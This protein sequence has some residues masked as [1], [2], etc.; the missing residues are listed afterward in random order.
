MPDNIEPGNYNPVVSTSILVYVGTYATTRENS[1]F[2]Y[3]L[4]PL[5]GALTLLKGFKGGEN[6][7]YFVFDVQHQFL[8][9]VNECE[10]Y[11]GRAGGAVCAFAMDRKTGFL[12]LLNRTSSLGSLPVYITLSRNGKTALVANYKGGNISVFPI[13]ANGQLATASKLIQL[14]NHGT[15]PNKERQESPHA[16]CI[17]LS[18]DGRFV[19]VVDLGND[20]VIAYQ[21]DP[22]GSDISPDTA[23]TA[24]KTHP[25]AG[26]RQLRFHSNGRFA[27]LI[28][29]LKSIIIALAYNQHTG[30]FTEIQA[31]STLPAGYHKENKCGGIRLTSVGRFLYASNRGHNSLAVY[32][33]DEISGRLTYLENIPSGGAWPREFTVVKGSNILL[34]ANQH[35]G[36]VDS[37]KI[38]PTSGCLTHSEYQ[39]KVSKPVFIETLACHTS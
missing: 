26:P 28:H 14:Q 1:I 2:L 18:P 24:F 30:T 34:V 23:I 3:K 38:N 15:G 5:T 36:T 25:G 19:F 29:E 27:Y 4:N 21:L 33:I 20:R 37:F 31:V 32:T 11:Q 10:K 16:H 9:A 22:D 6:P 8:Y 17:T 13:Q 35:S 12:S 39:V 7:S